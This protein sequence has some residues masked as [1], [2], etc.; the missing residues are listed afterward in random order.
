M[1][2][3]AEQFAIDPQA[4]AHA[5]L[6]AEAAALKVLELSDGALPRA[7]IVSE[8]F[9]LRAGGWEYPAA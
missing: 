4:A 1:P 3:H 5:L 8:E 9:L 7:E 6:L 2:E